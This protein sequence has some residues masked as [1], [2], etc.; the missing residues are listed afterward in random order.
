MLVWLRLTRVDMVPQTSH[1]CRY[2]VKDMI[3]ENGGM[4]PRKQITL[5]IHGFATCTSISF[6][7][8]KHVLE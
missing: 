1:V 7:A 6:W 4:K 5:E 3:L 8:A 2:A